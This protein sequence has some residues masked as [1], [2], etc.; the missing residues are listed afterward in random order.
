MVKK[1]SE[2]AMTAADAGIPHDTANMGPKFKAINVTD[3]RRR[4]D[5]PPRILR[6]FRTFA[7]NAE[8]K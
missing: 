3:K 4:K 5:K 2:E 1:V 7:A 8:D 6:R